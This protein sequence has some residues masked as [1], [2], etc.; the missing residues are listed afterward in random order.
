VLSNDEHGEPTAFAGSDGVALCQAFDAIVL[1]SA[2]AGLAVGR[3][4]YPELFNIAIAD[5][6]VRRPEGPGLRVRIYGLLEARLQ[7]LD[8]VVLGSLVDDVWPADPRSDPWLSRPMRQALG[9]D[10]PERRI[11]LAAHDFA[12]ALGAREVV[13]AYPA[14]LDG[15]PTVP[16]RFVQRLAAVAG[17]ARWSRA[18]AKG[19]RYLGWGRSLD[20]PARIKRI[21]KP[22]P[23]PPR[24][25]RPTSLSVTEVEHWLRDPYTIYAKHILKLRELDPVDLPPG[26]ADRGT[27]I[28]AALGEFTSTFAGALPPNPAAELIEIGRKH[29]AALEDY[30]EA[31]A[32]WWPRFQRIA[33]WF[34]AW[35]M[36]RRICLTALTAF[37]I[38]RPGR[39]RPRSRCASAF[40]RSSRWKPPCCARADFP[41]FHRAPPSTSSS[42]SRSRAA[43]QPASIS[44]S[45]SR[46]ATPTAMPMAH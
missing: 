39:C 9:L 44:R 34:A 36:Q 43:S 40:R 8:R 37:S 10:P 17:E 22:A 1:S 6:V 38:T 4:D 18:C 19:A 42:M 2:A 32:F 31:R 5:R 26:A 45:S 46:R 35:E 13:L 21:D 23:R 12:Q 33:H 16:S 28:H 15:A 11:S 41:V 29:F 7:S 25:T 27:V 20:R 14:K 3:A 30:P 24:S